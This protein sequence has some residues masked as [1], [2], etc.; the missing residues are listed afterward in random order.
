MT[1]TSFLS[2][3]YHALAPGKLANVVTF[4]EMTE[5]PARPPRPAPAG[6]A[7]EPVGRWDAD[8]FLDL[9]REIGWEWLWSSRL[10]MA[11]DKLEAKLAA[12]HMRSWCPV[13]D[14]RRMGIVEMDLSKPQETEISF[15]GLVPEAVGGGIGGWLMRE[16]IAIA[17]ARPGVRRLWLHTCHFDSPQALPFY[18]HMG[19]V[20]Y[21]R[22]VEV[23]DDVRLLGRL[24]EDAGPHIPVIRNGR[25]PDLD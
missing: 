21:A 3:G 20:P 19:F 14:G 7:L 25:R 8:T 12:P 10:L 23:H 9:Y 2:D 22:A 13:K 18:M 15:F 6:Y 4:L 11:R 16:A 17:F 24:G 5:P 1:D